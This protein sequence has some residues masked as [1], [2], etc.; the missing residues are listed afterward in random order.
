MAFEY[1]A[2]GKK[3]IQ[4]DVTNNANFGDY[5]MILYTARAATPLVLGDLTESIAPGYAQVE[6]TGANWVIT[7]DADYP[8]VSFVL[9]GVGSDLLG[10][11]IKRDSTLLGY[12]DFTDGPYV[13][14]AAGV[15]VGVTFKQVVA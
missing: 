4:E 7:V 2:I 15:S 10:Y 11:A 14:P 13:I 3:S 1:T 9:E 8:K 6:M 5:T 12:E